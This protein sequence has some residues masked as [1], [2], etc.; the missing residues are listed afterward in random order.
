[1]FSLNIF[2]FNLVRYTRHTHIYKLQNVKG[3]E[4]KLKAYVTLF[5]CD[6]FKVKYRSELIFSYTDVQTINLRSKELNLE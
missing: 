3:L 4:R 2:Y 5:L 1:M 6:V